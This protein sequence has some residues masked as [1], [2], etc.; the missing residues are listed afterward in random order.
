MTASPTGSARPGRVKPLQRFHCQ[1]PHGGTLVLQQPPKMRDDD[2][3]IPSAEVTQSRRC[4]SSEPPVEVPE[5][6]R[7]PW[8][9]DG[10]AL[11][12][13]ATEHG[14]GKSPKNPTAQQKLHGG[15]GTEK[16]PHITVSYPGC[17]KDATKKGTIWTM[18]PS[19]RSPGRLRRRHP[20][21]PCCNAPSPRK[22]LARK[23]PLPPRGCG[24]LCHA[25]LTVWAEAPAHFFSD[26]LMCPRH[27]SRLAI[28]RG[29]SVSG[30]PLG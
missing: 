24:R 4:P 7:Q 30:V 21:P 17:A 22:I 20:A 27:C 9:R 25:S 26:F 14:D 11:P 29:R 6:I 23:R 19:W 3:T 18:R 13:S 12:R 28:V 10:L 2:G 15:A 8:S 1:S 5:A 16:R